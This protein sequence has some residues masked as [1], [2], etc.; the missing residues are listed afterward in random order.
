M[1]WREV[2]SVWFEMWRWLVATAA[3]IATIFLP[4]IL[5]A[6]LVEGWLTFGIGVALM[7]IVF[8]FWLAIASV[9][10]RK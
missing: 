7:A 5:L 9:R 10:E 4:F 2:F 8:T 3:V 6:W 1:N